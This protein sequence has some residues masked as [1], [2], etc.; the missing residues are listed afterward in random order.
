[1]MTRMQS[2]V[3]G[4]MLQAPGL[5]LMIARGKKDKTTDAGGLLSGGRLM[6]MIME[7]RGLL[8][9]M[10]W[11]DNASRLVAVHPVH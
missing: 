11:P 10:L 2:D 3:L 9:F 6:G 5:R 8:R 4:E 1:M 7:L